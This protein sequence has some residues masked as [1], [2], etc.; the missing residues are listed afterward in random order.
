MAGSVDA[1]VSFGVL[2][3]AARRDLT[4]Y[5]PFFILSL[6]ALYQDCTTVGVA[7]VFSRVG[8]CSPSWHRSSGLVAEVARCAVW[9]VK[10]KR[11]VVKRIHDK[12]ERVRVRFVRR[13]FLPGGGDH[14]EALVL[15]NHLVDI[16]VAFIARRRVLCCGG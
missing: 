3:W 13:A 4:M 12:R 14:A 7:N 2:V 11:A 1:S 16:R 6:F 15:E 8:R 10:T 9:I 5:R